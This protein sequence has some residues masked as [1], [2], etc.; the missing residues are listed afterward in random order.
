MMEH[1]QT[2]QQCI[3]RLVDTKAWDAPGPHVP[4]AVKGTAVTGCP[5]PSS[6]Y[7]Q[8]NARPQVS[9]KQHCGPAKMV[10]LRWGQQTQI[11]SYLLKMTIS[12]LF[13][14][15]AACYREVCYICA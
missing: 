3:V 4:C 10:T 6:T 11:S 15:K 5:A 9:L 8:C 7:P 2:L 12:A 13:R 14:K 1:F